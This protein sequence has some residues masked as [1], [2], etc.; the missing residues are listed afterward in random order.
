MDHF[1]KTVQNAS[2]NV[3]GQIAW[4]T[5]DL[6][7]TNRTEVKPGDRNGGVSW[8]FGDAINIRLLIHYLG[9]IHQPLHTV[10][11]FTKAH[12]EGDRG[13]NDFLLTEKEGVKNLHALWDSGVYEFDKDVI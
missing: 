9:D 11:R 6:D 7:P 12:Q 1:N 5:K 10:S 4:I 3:T 13:G 8:F 2:F